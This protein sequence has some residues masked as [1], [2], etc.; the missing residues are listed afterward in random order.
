[1][2]AAFLEKWRQYFI[3]TTVQAGIDN[4][5]TIEFRI[6]KRIAL[7]LICQTSS[8]YGAL[9]NQPTKSTQYCGL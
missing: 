3:L 6:N 7:K 5:F 8:Q 4:I 9:G 2:S 1:M